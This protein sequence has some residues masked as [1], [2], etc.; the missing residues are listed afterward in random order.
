MD[1][2]NKQPAEKYGVSINFASR[3]PESVTVVS[4]VVS[5]INAKTLE[6]DTTVYGAS[7]LVIEGAAATAIIQNGISGNKYQL[8]YTVTLS[9]G[10]IL[11]E[12]IKLVV[13]RQTI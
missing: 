11:Q 13:K 10:S 2:L 7:A 8:T 5:A 12:D 9:D 6:A 4:G 1:T 3:L